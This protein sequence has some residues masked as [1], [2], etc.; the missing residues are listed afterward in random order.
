MASSVLLNSTHL[1]KAVFNKLVTNDLI[2]N[3]SIHL[4]TKDDLVIK[5]YL[6]PSNNNIQLVYNYLFEQSG[7]IALRPS[8]DISYDETEHPILKL[9]RENIVDEVYGWVQEC[10][11][12]EDKN[13]IYPATLDYFN[14]ISIYNIKMQNI[15]STLNDI[16]QLFNFTLDLNRMGII[17]V[18]EFKPFFQSTNLF[19][20][21]SILHSTEIKKTIMDGEGSGWFRNP[22]DI[23]GTYSMSIHYYIGN[24]MLNKESILDKNNWIE[25]AEIAI[26]YLEQFIQDRCC[27]VIGLE[28]LLYCKNV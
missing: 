5:D 23:F 18:N 4:I 25:I 13:S 17:Y 11:R 8:L 12:E 6:I 22:K 27:L 10:Y 26:L 20:I 9:F 14:M 15:M 21:I 16:S 28:R 24:N 19:D 2:T 1:N 7:I 3:K